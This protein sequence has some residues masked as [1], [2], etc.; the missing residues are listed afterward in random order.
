[1]GSLGLSETEDLLVQGCFSATILV[2][3]R[4]QAL[5]LSHFSMMIFLGFIV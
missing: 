5:R 4:G 3:F 1:M 2:R